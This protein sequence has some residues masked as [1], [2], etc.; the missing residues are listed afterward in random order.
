[1]FLLTSKSTIRAIGTVCA[2]YCV[3]HSADCRREGAE[4]NGENGYCFL[5]SG[6]IVSF[7]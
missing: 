5:G 6:V 3:D 2:K 7:R 4:G 1:V